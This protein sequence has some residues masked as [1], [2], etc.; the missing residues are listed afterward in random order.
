MGH[1]PAD[2]EKWI[3]NQPCKKS[4]VFLAVFSGL[5]PELHCRFW[6]QY[7]CTGD[8]YHHAHGTSTHYPETP[9]FR[10]LCMLWTEE[11]S[12]NTW[13]FLLLEKHK[14]FTIGNRR[15]VFS[16]RPSSASKHLICMSL[17]F[18]ALECLILKSEVWVAWASFY[19]NSKWILAWD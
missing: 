4:E 15:L 7:M 1:L 18:I 6:T 12:W 11:L 14:D 19:K 17:S 9:Q 13:R 3:W 8:A 10:V 2:D 16:Y 5:P